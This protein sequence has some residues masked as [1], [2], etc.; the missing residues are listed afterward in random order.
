MAAEP[1]TPRPSERTLLLVLAVL[2]LALLLTLTAGW[3]AVRQ[4]PATPLPVP[5]VSQ[6]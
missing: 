3:L 1:A 5:S 4:P 2:T 6:G